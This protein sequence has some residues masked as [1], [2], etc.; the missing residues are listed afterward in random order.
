MLAQVLHAA[1]RNGLK[2]YVVAAVKAP[3]LHADKS[4]AAVRLSVGPIAKPKPVIP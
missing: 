2:R 4:I 1:N 3:M